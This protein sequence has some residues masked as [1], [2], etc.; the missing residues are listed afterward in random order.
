MTSKSDNMSRLDYYLSPQRDFPKVECANFRYLICS[1]PRCGSTLLG[2]MM[3]DTKIMGDPLEYFNPSYLN[4]YFRRFGGNEESVEGIVSKLETIRTSP[5]G[6][7]GI[8]IH[9]RHFVDLFK[10][11]ESPAAVDFLNSFDRIIFMRRHDRM[12][13]AIS[14]YR[15]RTTGIWSSLENDFRAKKGCS[16]KNLPDTPFDPV[17]ISECLYWISAQ[18]SGWMNLF[19]KIDIPFFEIYYEDFMEKWEESCCDVISYLGNIVKKENIPEKMLKKQSNGI[20]S[21]HDKFFNY[22]GIF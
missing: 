12:A 18:D 20:D 16:T 7:F 4:A 22:I 6:K 11:A 14:L 3:Y 19:N 9:F 2:Q 5:N 10:S 8:Q 15:A 1:S 17:R 13:Q 21:L